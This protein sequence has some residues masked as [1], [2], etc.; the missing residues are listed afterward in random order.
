[1][2]AN[3]KV[4]VVAQ[5]T[6]LA[7]IWVMRVP[8]SALVASCLDMGFC[9]CSLVLPRTG[10]PSEAPLDG[11]EAGCIHHGYNTQHMGHV[12]LVSCDALNEEEL[13]VFTV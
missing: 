7:S 2:I 3:R 8:T 10:S 9:C 4:R 1:M 6:T 12:H 5:K 11:N 13:L